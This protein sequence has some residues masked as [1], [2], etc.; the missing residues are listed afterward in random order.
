MT[1]GT[2]A[3]WL[4]AIGALL[5][6]ALGTLHLAYTFQ[7]NKF[8]PR[9]DALKSRMHDVSPRISSELSMWSAW[10]GFNGSH[11]LGAMLFGAVYGYLS[12]WRIDVLANDRV[13]LAIGVLVVVGYGALAKYWFSIPRR[14]IA[15]AALCF[16][17]GAA[18]VFKRGY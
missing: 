8:D 2:A 10:V 16:V 1:A 18:L 4:M 11:S 14:G 5:I 12:I 17:F 15:V 7:S 3:Q 6:G 9:D 13:L